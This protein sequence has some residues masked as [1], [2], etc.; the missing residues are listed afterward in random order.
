[1]SSFDLTPFR[2]VFPAAMTFFDA[3]GNLDETATRTHWQWLIDQGI[4]GLVVAG[5]SG[6]FAC[7]SMEERQRLF[8]AAVEVAAGRVPIVAGT[9]HSATKWTIE[10]S[11][12]ARDAG[13]DALIITLPYYIRP[14]IPSVLEHYRLLRRHTDLPIML[15]N[16]PGFTACTALS[17]QQVAELVEEDVVHMIKSTMESVIP[18]HELSF[19]V[20]EK[21][22]IFYGSF[23]AGYEALAA[24]AHGWISGILNVT[25]PTAIALYRAVVVEKDLDRGFALWKRLLPLV[26]LYTHQQLGPAQDLPIY[27]GILELWGRHGGFSRAPLLPLSAQQMEL[28]KQRLAASGWLEPTEP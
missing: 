3:Q 5:T 26:H 9:G 1:M 28:L 12:R 21:M 22:R 27:R 7:L 25:A 23:L 14:P 6:E 15:Y 18:V 4:D 2:G 8:R 24:G 19:L 16:N 20:G 13:V 17:P 11:R 10:M